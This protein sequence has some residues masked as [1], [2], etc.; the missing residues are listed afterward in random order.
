MG[1]HWFPATSKALLALNSP[2]LSTECER[3]TQSIEDEFSKLSQTPPEKRTEGLKSL[4]W[5]FV[6][7]K[8]KLETQ[9]DRYEFFEFP[10]NAVFNEQGMTSY[11]G[12]SGPG[13]VVEYTLSHALFKISPSGDRTLVQKARVKNKQTLEDWVCPET[14]ENAML[15]A[16]I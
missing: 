5:K 12:L 13:T 14:A 9:I 8:A 7:F 6:E 10:T 2:V 4:V 15:D 3:I 16:M 1:H 11:T